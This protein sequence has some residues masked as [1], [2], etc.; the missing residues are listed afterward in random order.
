M[1][2]ILGLLLLLLGL[3]LVAAAQDTSS[4]RQT[5]PSWGRALPSVAVPGLGQALQGEWV[6]GGLFFV[7]ESFV[8]LEALHFWEN[9]Y[10]RAPGDNAG[11]RYDRETAGGLA[12]WYGLGAVFCAGDAYYCGSPGAEFSPSMAALRSVVFPGWGQL[13]NGKRLK[14]AG[15]FLAQ[16]GMG[17]SAYTQ[18][19]RFLYYD[20]RGEE[21]EA[22]FYKNDRNRLL[23]WSVGLVIYSAADAF[24]DCHLRN[25]D[26]TEV[27]TLEPAFFL[28][29]N[30]PGLKLC[31]SLP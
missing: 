16:T 3:S 21:M 5:E 31:F 7:G 20:A 28:A 10:T 27:A 2:F 15:I 23:W 17:F 12:V 13:S 8:A 19:Q 30:A 9:Q 22:R 1:K 11:R 29:Q 6:R 24:V 14:A 25:W 18:H 26:V 4:I